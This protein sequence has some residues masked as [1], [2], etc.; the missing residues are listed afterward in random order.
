MDPDL[1]RNAKV[2]PL[3]ITWVIEYKR[4]HSGDHPPHKSYSNLPILVDLTC[5][6]LQHIAAMVADATLGGRVNLVPLDE[7]GDIYTEMAKAAQKDLKSVADIEISRSMV[8]QVIMTIP[9]NAGLSTT[10]GYLIDSF[11]YSGEN[12]CYYLPSDPKQTPLKYR[13]IYKIA[14]KIHEQFFKDTPAVK[15]F[16]KYLRDMTSIL[17]R[18]GLSVQ[19]ETPVGTQIEQRYVKFHVSKVQSLNRKQKIAVNTPTSFINSTKQKNALM[20]NIIHSM[21]GANIVALV[22]KLKNDGREICVLTIHDCFGTH[23]CDVGTVQ[24]AV[25]QSFRLLYIKKDFLEKFHS[26]CVE[27]VKKFS[28]GCAEFEFDTEKGRLIL[29]G[30]THINP[31]PKVK[32]IYFPNP[33]K[34]GSLDISQISKSRHMIT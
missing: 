13:Q 9:Y 24:D 11:Q 10:T 7:P 30:D 2:V 17:S 19:W 22:E 5:N 1:I 33:P 18:L 4:A 6:G 23:A 15:A 25:R 16:V 8:K 34:M 28:L 21:D 26:N 14:K 31:D 3:F 12:G 27:S 32:E 20:P 29:Y